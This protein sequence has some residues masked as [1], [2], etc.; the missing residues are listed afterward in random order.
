MGSQNISSPPATL[1]EN[2]EYAIKYASHTGVVDLGGTGI[3]VNGG[4][5]T[6]LDIPDDAVVV[7]VDRTVTPPNPVIVRNFGATG[8]VDP[9]RTTANI[10]FVG[11]DKDGTPFFKPDLPF[12][13]EEADQYAML[14]V[15]VHTDQTNIQFTVNLPI[16]VGDKQTQ[17][18][19]RIEGLHKSTN[20]LMYS[21]N[22]D[23][24]L[25]R[26]AGSL[27]GLGVGFAGGDFPYA[28]PNARDLVA[29]AVVGAGATGAVLLVK[30]DNT[31]TVAGGG[32]TLL[33]PTLYES[34][35]GVLTA[36]S[37]NNKWSV[38]L[39]VSFREG[40]TNIQY[41]QTEYDTLEEAV[42][43]IDALQDSY[44]VAPVIEGSAFIA[45]AIAM[46]KTCTATNNKATCVIRNFGRHGLFG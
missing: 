19:L 17:D 41:G 32:G 30:S 10:T 2:L 42:A 7:I 4:D 37:T 31:N 11:V 21:G 40:R 26:S 6:L 36:L 23:L 44:T 45:A 14:G 9:Y 13:D 12:D 22:A 43:A 46:Q 24:T 29:E 16:I 39:I 25:Q 1:G 5:N 18:Y 3:S 27:Y 28:R 38:K 8:V 33:D 20:G 35:P 34:S 15:A